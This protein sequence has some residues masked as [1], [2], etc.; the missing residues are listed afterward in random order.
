MRSHIIISGPGRSGT[1]YLVRLLTELGLPTGFDKN[2]M[3]ALIDPICKGGLEYNIKHEEAPYIVKCPN[4]SKKLQSVLVTR[5]IKIDHAIICV[6]KINDAV[7]SRLRIQKQHNTMDNVCGGLTG[8]QIPKE[9][10]YY[11]LNEFYTF[12]QVLAQYDIPIT[13]VLFP[14]IVINIEYLT[15]NIQ[16]I[17]PNLTNDEIVRAWEQIAKPELINIGTKI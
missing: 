12:M 16:K 5:Q 15:K 9:Q 7:K 6:R 14:N 2:T 3:D 11:L 13:L 17:F 4:M 10:K 8:T 1:T